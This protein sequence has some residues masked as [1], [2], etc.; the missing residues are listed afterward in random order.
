MSSSSATFS[1]EALDRGDADESR[2]LW[3]GGA[4]WWCLRSIRDV[5]TSA[6]AVVVADG[7]SDG[8]AAGD[9]RGIIG[10]ATADSLGLRCL[11][12]EGVLGLDC[13]GRLILQGR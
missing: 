6:R 13:R 4:V 2:E 8:G 11:F 9:L 1:G 10:G 3:E 7:D 5:P 12:S